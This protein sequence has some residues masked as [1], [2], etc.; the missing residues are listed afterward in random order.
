[1]NEP[2]PS[3]Q[4]DGARHSHSVASFFDDQSWSWRAR[5][6]ATTFDAYNYQERGRIALRWLEESRSEK[7]GRPVLLEIGC[8][9]GVQAA[10][11]A[12]QGWRVIAGD[13]STGILGKASDR[14]TRPSWLVF[15]AEFPP[16][17]E[18]TLDAVMLLGVIGYLRDPLS[19]LERIRTLLKP[20]GTLVISWYAEGPYLLERLGHAVSVIPEGAYLFLKRQVFGHPSASPTDGGGFYRRH[21]QPF[22]PEEFIH[23][24]GRA[25]FDLER[26]RT[27]NYGALRFM[28][29]RLWGERGDILASRAVERLHQLKPMAGIGRLAR[30]HVAWAVPS[31]VRSR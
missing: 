19:A 26:H 3:H 12:Q 10:Q 21:N 7:E 20:D 25:G 6:S 13:F 22:A 16:I 17:R 4:A 28:G 30:T 31:E 29:K 5:Y 11:A 9:A 15:D 2:S 1:M 23:L 18:G 14:D 8:G 27:V 24:L